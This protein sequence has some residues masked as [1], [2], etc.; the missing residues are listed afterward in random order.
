MSRLTLCRRSFNDVPAGPFSIS[1]GA[2]N[3]TTPDPT[4]VDNTSFYPAYFNY[5]AAGGGTLSLTGSI[6]GLPDGSPLLAATFAPADTRPYGAVTT[7]FVDPT[8]DLVDF[9]GLLTVTWVN[10]VLLTDL[11]AAGFSQGFGSIGVTRYRNADTGSLD[12]LT[13]MTLSVTT[14]EPA[15][16]FFLGTGLLCIVARWRCPGRRKAV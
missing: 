2:L 1:G 12:T 3:F 7:A 14:P 9:S 11:G 13:G 15:T 16:A 6:F 5:Y 10:P 8:V 4:S